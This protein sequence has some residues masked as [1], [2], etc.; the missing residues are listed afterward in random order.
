MDDETR[1][2]PAGHTE[3]RPG[4]VRA[5]WPMAAGALIRDGLGRVLLVNPTYH[6]DRWLLA[7]G[8]MDRDGLSPK[9]TLRRE[10][11]EELGLDLPVGR[12]LVVDWIPQEGRFFEETV[13]VFD[14]GVLD[15]QAR[16]AVRL[17]EKELSG[18]EFFELE[19]ACKR[20]AGQDARRLREA[21]GVLERGTGSEYL[22][23][24]RIPR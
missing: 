22:E 16:A 2:V 20:L 3:V 11:L 1:V 12:L 8:G 6:A 17:P 7:G 24:G 21:Y 15:E 5:V 23:S 10:L 14:C 18:F 13:Y 9:E 19:E 4:Y